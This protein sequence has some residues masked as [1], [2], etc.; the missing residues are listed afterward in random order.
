MAQRN[1]P[2]A[3]QRDDPSL[4]PR[5]RWA[6]W[7]GVAL[8][9]VALG[10]CAGSS[11]GPTQPTGVGPAAKVVFTVQPSNAA[12]GAVNTPAVQVT[13]QDAQGNTVTTA[14][15]SITVAIGTNPA[16]GTLAGTKTVAAASGVA[17][18]S[19]LSLNIVGSGYTLTATATGL[20]S[21]TSSAFNISAGAA[22][23][24]VFTVQPSNAAA[25]AM[26][27]PAVQVTV[28]DAQGNTVTTA[29]TSITVAIGT[30]P[31]SGT[32][33]GATTVA[34]LNGVATFSALS[35]NAA[36]TGYT[37]TASA[38]G[39]TGA[40]SNAF[41]ISVGLTTV[42][43]SVID[44]STGSGIQGA[45]AHFLRSGVQ[46]AQVTAGT[47]GLYHTTLTPGTYDVSAEATGYVGVTLYNTVVSG[48]T[49]V[50]EPLT[51]VP[52][53]PFPGG[54]S[55]SIVDARTGVGISG[56]T[57]ELRL[58]M[59]AVSGA[60]L[61]T[62]SSDAL[63]QYQFSSLS[64]NTY[65]VLV[66]A[67]GYT[68]AVRTGI[69]G[70]GTAVSGQNVALSSVGSSTEVRIVLTWGISP[71]DLDS[72]LTGPT[73]DASRFHV[74]YPARGS[75]SGPPWAALDIDDVTS[76]GPE[77]ITIVQQLFGVYRYSF[78]DYTD[79][80]STSSVA[81]ANSG[82]RVDVYRGSTLISSFFPPPQDGTLWTVFE[83]QG[84]QL[85]A[86]NTMT[87]E[88]NPSTVQVRRVTAGGVGNDAMV[89]HADV[90]AHPKP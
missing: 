34:A 74:Y 69:D 73:A 30:N 60:P 37:L 18:F 61:A 31:A 48:T 56:A 5:R 76:Y 1:P 89:I 35:L 11:A 43:G 13:V 21:A 44:G 64:A 2:R 68:T 24:L 51:L 90:T 10:G 58:G 87:Y 82:A 42:T 67:T 46:V 17:T 36:G 72:H 62:T 86:V 15:T 38:T 20:T 19:T 45:V 29:T 70:G 22:A 55:G 83:L 14:T 59:N 12:A 3:Q 16:S 41:N 77:T 40:T 7:L 81:L 85:T 50:I 84:E 27:T 65:T 75:L 33:S 25:G 47:G 26:N 8:C 28:Q 63:G 53:S 57:V 80:A 6:F 23:K 39:L 88:S 54:I 9:G 78:H 71:S 52:T 49:T 66:N 4:A 79:L 32:L